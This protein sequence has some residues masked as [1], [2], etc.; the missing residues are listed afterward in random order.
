MTKIELQQANTKLATEN[1]ALRAELSRLS[2]Q[3]K[4]PR[5]GRTGYQAL[6]AELKAAGAGAKLVNGVITRS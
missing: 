5:T 2:T 1:D 4:A 6:L 3:I